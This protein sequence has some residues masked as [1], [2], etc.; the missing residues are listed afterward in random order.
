MNIYYIDGFRIITKN[1]ING[2]N[3]PCLFSRVFVSKGRIIK[4]GLLLAQRCVPIIYVSCFDNFTIYEIDLDSINLN[5]IISI[6]ERYSL[7]HLVKG[8]NGVSIVPKYDINEMKNI[9]NSYKK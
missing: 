3:M 7:E 5:D 2:H 6:M 8:D 9:L 4:L 1:I